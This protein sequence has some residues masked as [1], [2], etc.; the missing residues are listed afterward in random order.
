MGEA[1]AMMAP[2]SRAQAIRAAVF[3]VCMSFSRTQE[4]AVFEPSIRR[5]MTCPPIIPSPPEA[6]DRE[7][8]RSTFWESER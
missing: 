6:L 3:L 7:A 4:G 8:M 2:H 5:S 1:L